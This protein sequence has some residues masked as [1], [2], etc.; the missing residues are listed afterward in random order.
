MTD[1]TVATI[2]TDGEVHPVP[3]NNSESNR[4][5]RSSRLTAASLAAARAR[6][7]ARGRGMAI[8]RGRVHIAAAAATDRRCPR[9]SWSAGRITN[10]RR[11]VIYALFADCSATRHEPRPGR[12]STWTADYRRAFKAHRARVSIA[13]RSRGSHWRTDGGA[14]N[15]SAPSTAAQMQTVP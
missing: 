6:L 10:V 12:I 4:L 14:D 11:I 1:L 7:R 3:L 15:N 5:N 8:L 9:V 13:I 2:C